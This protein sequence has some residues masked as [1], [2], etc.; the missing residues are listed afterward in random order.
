MKSLLKQLLF[1][2]VVL[3][4]QQGLCQ[5]NPNL[6]K[7][8]SFGVLAGEYGYD[9]GIGLELG[10]PSLFKNKICFRI[11]GTQNWLEVYKASYDRWAKYETVAISM[12]YNTLIV[13]R[14]R[15]YFD[16]GTYHIFPDK[17]VSN[18]TNVQGITSSIGVELFV[19][20][21]PKFNV[22]YYFSSGIG[23]I[24]AHAEKLENKPRYGNGFVFNN[25][26]RFYLSL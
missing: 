6:Y 9:A 19:V 26:F 16:I 25:G 8:F 11:K 4:T 22:S 7:S 20:T 18:K 24:H 23:Y 14:G 12:V 13:D 10:T 17:K 2:I 5:V 15:V 21:N 1:L 3:T